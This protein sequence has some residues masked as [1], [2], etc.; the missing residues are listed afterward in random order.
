M[1]I[2]LDLHI[3]KYNCKYAIMQAKRI[4]LETIILIFEVPVT[5]IFRNQNQIEVN[6]EEQLRI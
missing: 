1:G 6:C 3:C 5:L 4:E 2:V